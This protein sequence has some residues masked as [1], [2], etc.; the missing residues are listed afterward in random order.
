MRLNGDLPVGIIFDRKISA[1]QEKNRKKKPM[2]ILIFFFIDQVFTFSP[3]FR[4][5]FIPDS[6]IG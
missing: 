2:M 5:C 4:N 1:G 6:A 3:S